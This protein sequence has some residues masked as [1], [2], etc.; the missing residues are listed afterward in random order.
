MIPTLALATFKANSALFTS[1]LLLTK[2]DGIPTAALFFTA[3][4]LKRMVLSFESGKDPVKT[5]KAF[6]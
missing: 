6:S 2:D 1:G 5:L 3:I 4:V